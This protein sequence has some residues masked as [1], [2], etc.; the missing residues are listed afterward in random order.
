VNKC[1]TTGLYVV[2]TRAL[3]D[4]LATAADATAAALLEVVCA[5][6]REC[7]TRLQEEYSGMAAELA[8]PC[9]TGEDVIAL[10]R[11]I[12]RCTLS[13]ERLKEMLSH[14]KA[15][16]DLVFQFRCNGVGIV[17]HAAVQLWCA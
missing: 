7:N 12:S 9:A 8:R 10:K 6:A 13:N 4:Q 2:H 14:S 5:A 16:D 15:R 11:C 17:T 3:K 1:V